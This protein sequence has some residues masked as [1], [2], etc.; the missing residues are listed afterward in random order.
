[1]WRTPSCALGSSIWFSGVVVSGE[2]WCLQGM[3]SKGL[4]GGP[5]V[6]LPSF[7]SLQKKR[8]MIAFHKFL[9]CFA[10]VRFFCLQ[11]NLASVTLSQAVLLPACRFCTPHR[12]WGF[13]LLI[14]CI[15]HSVLGVHVLTSRYMMDS[16]RSAAFSIGVKF[17]GNSSLAFGGLSVSNAIDK[18]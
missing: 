11:Q 13:V 2:Q 4:S 5:S 14:T 9:L 12:G 7:L 15:P 10:G 8:A 1:M 3:D 6:S 16:C 17:R 18:I